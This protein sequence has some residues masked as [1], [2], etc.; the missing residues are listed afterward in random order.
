VSA[1]SV[2]RLFGT[3]G[4]RGVA[5]RDLTPE[6]ATEIG[7]ALGAGVVAHR[8]VAI[9]R[10]TRRSGP[11]LEA[12]LAAGLAA[13]G[14]DVVS[15]GVL[16]TPAIAEAVPALGAAAGAVISASH[17]PYPDNGIKLIGPDGFKLADGDEA[18]IERR[19][20][21]PG[22]IARPTGAALGDITPDAG[23]AERYVASLIE[24]FPER[25]DGMSVVVDCANGAT[26][27][28]APEV[29]R[30]LGARISVIN[31]S[32][33]GVN[34]NEG[35]GSTHPEA[36]QAAVRDGGHQLGFAFD[37]D[38]DR[39]LAVDHDGN[40]VDGDQILA[41]LALHLQATGDL[42]GDAVVTTTMTNLGFRRAMAHR[43][44]EVRWTDV[45]D[46]YVLAEMRS[47]GY[48]LGG[49]QSGHII[50][51]RSGPTGDGLATAL[52]VLDALAGSGQTLAEAAAV[53]RRSPQKLVGIRSSRKG[54]LGDAREV[55]EQVRAF[56]ETFGED[57]RVV[58]RASGT[59]PLVRVMVEA[60][61][62]S[63]CDEWC[64][65]IAD[66]VERVL[67]DA[68]PGS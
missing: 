52:M 3:D 34:I 18:E 19:L 9:G 25:L 14:V 16:P 66:V 48:V 35:C 43:G 29:L 28:T 55:W 65:R 6:L 53:V 39:V 12:A 45:G 4:V 40:L 7:R 22:G 13:A 5:N 54:E 27:V 63:D 67:G 30:R 21:D 8:R 46:R 64:T 17:N 24:R 57:G 56:E 38:G 61:E 15:L 11:M 62:P 36:L 23:A 50:N 60:P 20:A 47:G 68:S 44:I 41:I 58:V 33:D 42:A 32:P 59:E 26:A 37:G 49:E 10:D 2:R 51:L 1:Q 31:A